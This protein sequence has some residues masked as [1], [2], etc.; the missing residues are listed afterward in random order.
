MRPNQLDPNYGGF[1]SSDDEKNKR[2]DDV[3]NSETLVIDSGDPF[4]Q[5]F[6]PGARRCGCAR[7]GHRI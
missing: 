7:N 5:H 1:D 3:E 6:D 2:V 4:M